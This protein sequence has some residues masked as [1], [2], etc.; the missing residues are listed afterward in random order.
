MILCE[1]EGGGEANLRHAVVD[2]IITKDEK[3]L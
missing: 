3:V 1:F 2:T